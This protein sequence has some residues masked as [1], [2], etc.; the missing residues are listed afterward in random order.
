M[1][2]KE[3]RETVRNDSV[4]SR[5]LNFCSLRLARTDFYCSAE[6]ARPVKTKDGGS[7]FNLRDRKSCQSASF[8]VLAK[9]SLPRFLT[10]LQPAG[11]FSL[12]M[13]CVAGNCMASWMKTASVS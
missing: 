7:D 8:D 2:T 4:T 9:A 12:L 11:I 6:G 10:T 13:E 1:L 3:Y 5:Q